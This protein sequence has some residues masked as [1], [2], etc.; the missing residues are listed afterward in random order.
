VA[1]LLGACA[2]TPPQVDVYSVEI[3][4]GVTDARG[5]FR[6]IYCAVLDQ[7]GKDL[8]D[9]RSC[10]A[11][12]SSTNGEPPGAG[13]PVELGASRRHLVAAFVPGIGY[14]CFKDWLDPPGTAAAHVRQYDYGLIPIEVDALSGIETNA[15]Q[16]RDAIM[17]MPPESGPARLILVGYSKGAPDVLEAVVRYPETRDRVAAVVSAAGAVGG[18]ALANDASQWQADL[19]RFWPGAECGEGD[20]RGVES[21]RPDVRKRWLEQNPLPA[22]IRY[23]SLVTLPTPDRVSKL[24]EVSKIIG[25]SYRQLG[26]IDWRNDGQLIYSDQIIPGSTLLGFLNADH[27]AIAISINRSH[28]HIAK[29][30]VDQN[31]Y[32]REAML[33]A[34]LRFVEEDLDRQAAK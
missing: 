28:P 12:L 27:W 7:H 29:S 3:P 32:P 11:A 9:Y 18:S 20:G 22:G 1:L 24:I 13:E 17:A 14:S 15:R 6:E 34:V 23:Y 26:D 21:L 30:F 19:L 25:K 16:V 5:R 4:A 8:P 33:E 2:V 31:A 10:D